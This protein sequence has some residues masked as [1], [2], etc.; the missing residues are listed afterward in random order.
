MTETR[1]VAA[2]D[3]GTT[4]TRCMIFDHKG[5]VVAADQREHKQIFPQAGWVEHDAVEIWNNVRSVSAGALA[6]AD[7]TPSDIA[8][9]GITNQRETA[10]VW[11]RATGKPVYNAIVW[12]DTRTDRI[13]T[14]LGGGDAT[15]YTAKTGLPLATYFSGP[16]VKWILDN[17]EGA[18]EKADAGELCFGNMDTWVLWNMTGGVDGGLHYT[19]PTNASRTLLMDLDTLSWD[20]GICADMGIP[21]SMLPEIRSSSEVYGN[22]R[23]RGSLSGV[24]IAGILGDQQAATFGQACLSPGEAKNTYGTGNF[25]LLNTGTDKVMSKNGLLTTVCYKIGDQPT[26]Y[27]LEGSIAVTGSLVQWLRDNLGMISTA[28]DIE[29]D[30]RSVDD[31]GGAYFVPAFSGLFAPHWRSDARGAIVGL[32]RFVNKGHLARAVLEATAYQTREV[33]EAMNA[34]SGVDL[35]VLKVDGGMVVNELLMQFQSDI[36]NV[37]V[38]RPVV[39]ETT[40]LGAAYAAGLAVGFWASE[41]EIRENW[42]EDKTWTPSMDDAE[43]DK[44]YAGWKKA[45]TRTLDWVDAE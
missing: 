43:R 7:L 30:A 24:P 9:V 23:E 29:T 11:E 1:Y 37:D 15:K 32:T 13:V 22:V 5:T 20:E 34:D 31:N 6:A 44:L 28:A 25:V 35:E 39:A 36:L 14:K 26:V 41:D 12:Q 40:A 18:Q 21:M 17:V 33:I 42:A 38:V 19:D 8:A 10:L 16:K 3:Q 27:A 4:S 2:I 45:V